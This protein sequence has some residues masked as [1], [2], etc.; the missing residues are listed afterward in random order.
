M[1][2]TSVIIPTFNRLA[3]LREAIES[4][5]AQSCQ[6]FELIVVDDGS[7]DGTRAY[8]AGLGERVRYL[9]QKNSGPSAA[10]N[11]GISEAKGVYLAFLDSDDLWQKDKLQAQ[12]SVMEADPRAQICYTDEIWIRRGVR[13]NQKKKHRKYSGWIFEKCLPLCIVS[14]SSV[15]MRR[16]FFETVG[17]FDET[18]PACEDYDLWLKAS[19][20]VEFHYIAKFLIVKRG[21]HPD[22]LSAEWGLDRYR[23]RVLQKLLR[24]PALTQSKNTLIVQQLH[25]K[26]RILELGFRKRGKLAEAERYL[27]LMRKFEPAR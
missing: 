14:P 7:T 6:D 11:R 13:V 4:V 1:V 5:F 9:H 2:Q 22:Q 8:L 15:L 12:I 16:G 19:L 18:L 24:N 25:E 26:C 23:V 10:R 27:D 21:G 20:L 3:F 17:L